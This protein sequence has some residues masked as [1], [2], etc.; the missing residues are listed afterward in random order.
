RPPLGPGPPAAS[1]AS[2]DAAPAPGRPGAGRRRRPRPGA[3]PPAGTGPGSEVFSGDLLEH[4]LVQGQLGDQAL[5][6]GVLDL[7]LSEALGV[8]ALEAAV[9]LLPAVVGRLADGELLAD[10]GEGQAVGQV[11]LGL[12]K[13]VDDLLRGVS[14]PHESSPGPRRASET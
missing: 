10:L 7:Q 11:G 14:L 9:A 6:P 3:R 12:P 4:L 5:Q 1:A 8:I 13:L 2:S